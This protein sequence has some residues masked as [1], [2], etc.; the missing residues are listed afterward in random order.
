MLFGHRKQ[1]NTLK[2]VEGVIVTKSYFF[3]VAF[4][5]MAIL[6]SCRRGAFLASVFTGI[7]NIAVLVLLVFAEIPR[8][9][10]AHTLRVGGVDI[11][12]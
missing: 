11:R 3:A 12:R 5:D 2:R 1:Q 10:N 9:S 7:A 6:H 4:R 8:K